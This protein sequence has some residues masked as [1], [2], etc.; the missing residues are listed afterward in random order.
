MKGALRPAM[1]IRFGLLLPVLIV[2]GV[3]GGPAPAAANTITEKIEAIKDKLRGRSEFFTCLST[4][5]DAYRQS[6]EVES[7]GDESA[8]FMAGVMDSA[9][10]QVRANYA[11]I[12]GRS[13]EAMTADPAPEGDP[14]PLERTLD[15]WREVARSHPI[16][17]CFSSMADRRAEKARATAHRVAVKMKELS[18]D[19]FKQHIAG[20]LH[21][22]IGAGLVKIITGGGG[23]VLTRERLSNIANTHY[24]RY[25][26]AQLKTSAVA[27]SQYSATAVPSK[28]AEERAVTW[29]AFVATL[30]PSEHFTHEFQVTL[31][32]EIVRGMAYQFVEDESP[33]RG[34]YFLNKAMGVL[35]LSEGISQR[36]VSS[37][38]GLVPE[39]GAAIC[40]ATLLQALDAV[41]NEIIL[42]QVRAQAV[43]LI[44]RG[45]D[46]ALG[47]AKEVAL[48]HVVKVSTTADAAAKA[49]ASAV[50]GRALD[51]ELTP[52]KSLMDILTQ[53]LLSQLADVGT[54]ELR[55]AVAELGRSIIAL[56]QN[57]PPP[58]AE[59]LTIPAPVRSTL[60]FDDG[61]PTMLIP[62]SSSESPAMGLQP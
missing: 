15:S 1:R 60:V 42:P 36:I 45:I 14:L 59:R 2:A 5:F 10:E 26:I 37:V 17:S 4:A 8:S 21:Q 27:L 25:L 46:L 49:A 47:K 29:R 57:P 24:A 40:N 7:F 30:G 11:V 43:S 28:P 39:V 9:R 19:L 6:S 31:G 23:T 56:A 51:P 54:S 20:R 58:P 52:F 22:A 18:L 55:A 48:A 38:C 53:D 61:S 62:V 12:M 50:I 13:L 44:K 41:W 34:G 35:Q 32:I 16:I 3:G 33:G